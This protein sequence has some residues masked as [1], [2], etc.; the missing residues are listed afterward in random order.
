VV[1]VRGTF[2]SSHEVVLR[3][4]TRG[5]T[6]GVDI[7][8]PLRIAGSEQAVLVDRGWVPL[9]QYD[10]AALQQWAAM[11]EAQVT[12]IAR[13]SQVATSS[14]GP[15]DIDPASGELKT[16]FRADIGRIGKQVPYALLP[17]WIEAQPDAAAPDLPHPQPSIQLSEGSHLS[18]ALQ[19]FSFAVIGLAGYAALVVKQEQ[20]RATAAAQ[21]PD[22][23]S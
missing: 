22:R 15:Q 3:N 13:A 5:G 21:Q 10:Q 9:L 11:G 4:R 18:Y 20:T 8:T 16:W 12:G 14:W 17:I 6:P 23:S 19:W 7:L 1:T 2:D